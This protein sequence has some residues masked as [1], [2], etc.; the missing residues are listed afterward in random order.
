MKINEWESK[1]DQIRKWAWHPYRLGNCYSNSP[2]MWVTVVECLNIIWWKK[3]LYG[4]TKIYLVNMSITIAGK[5]VVPLLKGL[6]ALVLHT[7]QGVYGLG[8][9]IVKTGVICISCSKCYGLHLV[10]PGWITGPFLPGPLTSLGYC[11]SSMLTNW[12]WN[13]QW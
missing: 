4:A 9:T 3:L 5:F 2:F 12:G 13:S 10:A 11:V 1:P 8:L 6:F 7:S